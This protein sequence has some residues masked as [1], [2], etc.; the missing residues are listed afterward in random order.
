MHDLDPVTDPG[1][2]SSRLGCSSSRHGSL[3]P[4]YNRKT[5][6]G[7]SARSSRCPPLQQ[8]RFLRRPRPFFRPFVRTLRPHPTKTD[9]D[10]R[11]FQPMRNQRTTVPDGVASNISSFCAASSAGARAPFCE[12]PPV[13]WG[14][15]CTTDAENC[16][17]GDR[18]P[19]SCS[20]V[21]AISLDGSG[22]RPTEIQIGPNN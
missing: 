1:F 12:A 9:F 21:C 5:L 13:E 20:H 17:Q 10:R 19:S 11:P 3:G 2:L 15:R 22:T 7:S 14:H 18:G 6:L 4:R 16:G 8:H